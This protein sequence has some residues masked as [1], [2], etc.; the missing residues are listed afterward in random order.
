MIPPPRWDK[1]LQK[2]TLVVLA[3]LSTWMLSVWLGLSLWNR[4]KELDRQQLVA[5]QQ[6]A[7]LEALAARQPHIE[8][9]ARIYASF[10]A[11]GSDEFLQQAL[12]DEL[13][14]FAAEDGL[15][16]NLKPRP[17]QRD[18]DVHR[19]GVELEVEATQGSLLAFLDRLFSSPSLFELER[20]RI[21]TA[22]SAEYPLRATLV[23]NKVVIPR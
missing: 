13:E 2:P 23:V 17:I 11:D 16:L 22:A 5:W 1:S 9:Q 14:Q 8:Q 3:G 15:Q 10:W 12:F 21:S 20:V 18:G 19:L 7:R 6:R 4:L